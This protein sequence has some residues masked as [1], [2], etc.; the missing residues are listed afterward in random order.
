MRDYNINDVQNMLN[1]AEMMYKQI[2]IEQQ[3]SKSNTYLEKPKKNKQITRDA[4]KLLLEKMEQ[5]EED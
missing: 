4:L 3:H 5:E 1:Q 2:E